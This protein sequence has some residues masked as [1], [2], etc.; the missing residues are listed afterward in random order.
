MQ[1]IE[2]CSAERAARQLEAQ[3]QLYASLLTKHTSKAKKQK[4]MQSLSTRPDEPFEKALESM[5][6]FDVEAYAST[7][8]LDYND[9][10]IT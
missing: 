7:F 1:R 5:A 4:I 2:R 3:N 10:I 8:K 9:I 6:K